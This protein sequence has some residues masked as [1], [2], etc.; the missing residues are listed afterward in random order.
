MRAQNIRCIA[1]D[2]HTGRKISRAALIGDCCLVLGSEGY[3]ISA[4][5][6][7]ACDEAVTIPMQNGVDS[8]NVG[9]AAAIFLYEAN[10]QRKDT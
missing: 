10:R 9:S 5:V 8:L 6:L 7:A 4:E 1:A 3:G 2:P